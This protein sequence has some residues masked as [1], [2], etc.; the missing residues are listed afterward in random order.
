VVHNFFPINSIIS[1]I[2]I[3]VSIKLMMCRQAM[4][5]RLGKKWYRTRT[6]VL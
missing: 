5:V 1:S 6:D 3:F 2:Q 4:E